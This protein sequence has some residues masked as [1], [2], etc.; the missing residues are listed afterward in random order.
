MALGI[1]VAEFEWLKSFETRGQSFHVHCTCVVVVF[2]HNALA[3]HVILSARSIHHEQTI[4]IRK[5]TA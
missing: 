3:L 5:E 1:D 4:R 2:H